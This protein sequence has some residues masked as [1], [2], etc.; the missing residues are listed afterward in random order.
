MKTPELNFSAYSDLFGQLALLLHSGVR[1][2]DGLSMIAKEE[3]DRDYRQTLESMSAHM[4]EGGSF[5]SALE[6]A[7][8]FPA[9]AIGLV[10]VAEQVGKTEG[11]LKSLSRYYESR[12]RIARSIKN[13]IT[14][15]AIL[16]LLML[17]VIVVLLSRVLP[18]FNEVY[19]SLGG[20]LTGVAAGLLKLGEWLGSALPYMGIALGV[21]AIIVAVLMLVPSLRK[22]IKKI[23][24]R[25][26]GDRG[27]QRKVNNAHFAQVLAMSLSSGL[28][29]EEGIQLAAQLLSESP[30]AKRR[31]EKCLGL[32]DSG[33][34]LSAALS[35]SEMLS[36]SAAHLLSMAFKAGNGDEIMQQIADKMA[37]EAEEALETAASRIEPALVL[38]TSLMVGAIL[39]SVM[40]PLIDIMKAIG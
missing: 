15:P 34:E 6:K 39:L 30:A 27:V 18:V 1:L 22:R 25:L 40:L 26:F 14:Y 28:P 35:K 23:F 36:P 11:T 7:G 24:T 5:F 17:V 16:L 37:Y 21:I 32:V 10:R 4:D 19:G 38:V 2:S 20:S 9:H 33:T 29:T 12:D 3:Q 31:C 8:C 13:A